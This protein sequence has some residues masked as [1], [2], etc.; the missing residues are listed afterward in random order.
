[1][2]YPGPLVEG[3]LVRRYKRFLC[4]VLIDGEAITA[5]L[6]NPGA[7]TS[8]LADAAPVRLWRSPDPKRKL[9]WGVEQIQVDGAWI[10]VNTARANSVVA[11]ALREGRLLGP[12][13]AVEP[14]QRYGLDG[15]TSRADFRVVSNGAV[16]WVEVK[17]V[18]WREGDG[19]LFPDARSERAERHLDDLVRVVARGERAILVFLVMRGDVNRV[20]PADARVPS[21]GKALRAA[22]AAGVE[23]IARRCE[24]SDAGLVLGEPLPVVV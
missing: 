18:S 11:E 19:A 9:A 16:A 17:A 13:S 10:G 24:L 5:H 7:M 4:D 6:A 2:N 1:M 22:I 14:E 20:A 23:V 15:S 3:V 12:L 8:C 21:Y